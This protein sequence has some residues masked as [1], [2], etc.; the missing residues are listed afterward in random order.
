MPSKTKTLA[1]R[2]ALRR[3]RALIGALVV[4]TVLIHL[5]LA[6]L[7][8]REFEHSRMLAREVEQSHRISDSLLDVL[9]LHRDVETGQRGYLLT[10]NSIFLQPYRAA[11]THAEG[12]FRA[13]EQALDAGS[14]LAPAMPELRRLSRAKLD[15]TDR[16]IEMEATGRQEAARA[17]V[18]GGGGKRRMDAIRAQVARMDAAERA[19]LVSRTE[20]AFAAQDG[21]RRLSLVLLA[22]LATLLTVAAALIGRTWEMRRQLLERLGDAAARQQ[23]VLD[24]TTD[25]I[26]TLNPS[27]SIESLNRAARSM[28]GYGEDDLLRRDVSVLFDVAPERGETRPF[29]ERLGLLDGV[30]GR[31]IDIVG[32]R[33]DGAT[34]P[35][36]V[37]VSPMV[38]P[39]GTHAV[40][41]IRDA[42][43]RHRVDRMK[44]EFVSTVSHELRTPLTSIAGSLGLLAGGAAGRLPDRA[45][46]LVGIA[47]ANSERLVR[48]V[49]DILDIE[50]IEAGQIR[51]DLR[52]V[53]LGDILARTAD[54]N[55][56]FAE[57]Y[58]VRVVIEDADPSALVTG[59]ADR[60]IQVFTNLLS[61]AVKFSPADGVVHISVSAREGC[62]RVDV[63]DEGR[64]IPAEFQPRLFDKFSQA[65]SSDTRAKGGSGLGLSIAREI[66][67]RHQ[68]VISFDTCEGEG[69]TFHVDL[70]RADEPALAAPC[71]PLPRIL[72]VE[73][74]VDMTRVVASALEGRAVTI[75]AHSLRQAHDLLRREC[76]DLML[77]DIGLT[78][79][80]GLD[81]L[82]AY[83]T[84][85]PV[86]IFTAQDTDARVAAR[87]AAVLVKSRVSIGRLVEAVDA[88]LENG[89]KAA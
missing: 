54:A 17:A 67:H 12:K 58:G 43:E 62:W 48:L 11:R 34:V 57:R 7:L 45:A 63:R 89:R 31:T 49:N 35:T 51:F 16:T 53:P 88:V 78:D 6:Y 52:P 47:H 69:T 2:R 40:A 21:A 23:A 75:A 20:H 14:P 24:S 22:G 39:S 41:V 32:R 72:H 82:D 44:T 25:A 77:L 27:G 3:N 84:W 76:F 42:T 86:I 65:D 8:D 38:L 71:G 1:R 60:L 26:I 68:G 5:L 74:D 29:L 81:L 61:N 73:D 59:D 19:R 28:Y 9:S 87:A 36:E 56:G 4:A 64:G 30:G 10:G 37:A 70:P 79:G 80:S 83:R 85:P 13:L 46:R 15:F 66:V 55:A 50:K 18:A 33:S